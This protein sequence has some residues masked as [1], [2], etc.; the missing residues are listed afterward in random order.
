M[1]SETIT[2]G[3]VAAASVHSHDSHEAHGHDHHHEESFLSKYVFSTDH[4]MI[5]KQFLLTG[6]IWAI[7]GGLFSVLFRLQLGYPDMT[8]PFL[9]DLFGKWAAGGRISNEFYYALVTMHGTILVFFVLT[10]G[11]SGTFANILIPLQ[12]GARDM[13]SGF[14]NMLSYWFFFLA[15]VVMFASLFIQTGPASGGWTIYPPLSALGQASEGSKLG[16]DYW[17]I[18]MALFIVSSLLGGLNYISTILNLRTK[19]MSM[20]RMPLTMWAIFFTAVLGVLSFPVLLSGAVLL[21]FDRNLGTSFYLSE[22][23]VKGEILPNE[24]GSAILFQHLFWFLGHPEVYIILLPAMGMVSEILSVNSRKPIFGYLAMVGSLFAIAILA[25]LVWAHHMFV[26]GLNPFLGAFFVLLTL[27][28][29]VPSAIK[30]FNWLTTIWKGNIRLTPGMLFAIGF[31]S[32]FISGGLTGIFLGNSTLDIHLHDTYFVVAH[33]HI[34]MGVASFFGMFAGVYH[35]FPKMYGRYLNNTMAYIHF[36]VTLVG[37]YL[38]F[39]PMHYSGLAG[40]PRRYTDWSNWQSFN[41]FQGMNSFISTVA[42]IVFAV[43]LLFVFNFFY[44]MFKG[45]KVKDQNPWG[46]NTLEWTTP[47]NPGHGNWPGDIPEVHR[48]AYDYGKD[49]REFIPQTEPVGA[50]ESK[51]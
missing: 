15:S 35:W 12:I 16:M 1:S 18:S 6:I 2:H 22:I 23:V 8:F 37:A 46:A 48:W 33:F 39:W 50:N 9:E 17:L 3:Q 36:W 29:A 11:L 27:L 7:I 13:A 38:I 26:T 42:M 14:L 28:I 25:F 51:H 10:A 24:G 5:G 45:R 19:G 41:Q 20:T 32:L 4:K 21:L 30:V 49:G 34:V 31:V 40:M 43:Q 47:I 44:S